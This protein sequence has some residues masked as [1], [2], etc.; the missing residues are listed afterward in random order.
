M[1]VL[2][3]QCKLLAFAESMWF[4]LL[5]SF[6]SAQLHRKAWFWSKSLNEMNGQMNDQNKT[7]ERCNFVKDPNTL[8]N[9]SVSWITINIF[10]VNW[11]DLDTECGR[12]VFFPSF[13]RHAL[14]PAFWIVPTLEG[15]KP[16]LWRI[17]DPVGYTLPAGRQALKKMN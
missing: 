2:K 1:Q 3:K 13:S 8:S 4:S 17:Q 12:L 15:K 5:S 10:N 16:W 11:L 6:E 9:L 14:N 7:K